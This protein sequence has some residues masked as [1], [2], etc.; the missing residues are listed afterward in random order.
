MGYYRANILKENKLALGSVI[1]DCLITDT[2]NRNV[3]FYS[4]NMLKE[5]VLVLDSVVK[6]F[7]ITAEKTSVVHKEGKMQ[8]YKES[9]PT[10]LTSA[11]ITQVQKVGKMNCQT[12]AKF[13]IVQREGIY[14][15]VRQR[16]TYSNGSRSSFVSEN[17]CQKDAQS[18][19]VSENDSENTDNN[20]FVSENDGEN[21]DNNA[22]GSE[23]GSQCEE[24]YDK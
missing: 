12:V 1:K 13:A 5:S 17:D 20:V 14:K 6:N 8:V 18:S 22:F 19:F 24:R 3:G 10:A 9:I 7:F 21:T 4:D 15:K 11:E 2:L 16:W 23:N